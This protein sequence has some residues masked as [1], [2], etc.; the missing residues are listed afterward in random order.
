MV[1][2]LKTDKIESMERQS[3]E[4]LSR[5]KILN[6]AEI[7]FIIV[8]LAIRIY[9]LYFPF[10]FFGYLVVPGDDAVN[11]YAMVKEVM[12]GSY[13]F[14]YPK[15]FHLIIAK[16][17]ILSGASVMDLFKAITPLMVVLPSVAVYIFARKQ[18][19]RLAGLIGFA[20]MLWGGCNY[21]LLAFGDGN[22][23]NI[24]SAGFFMPLAFL[25]VLRA[26]ERGRYY[27]Y[28]LAFLFVVLTVLTHHLTTALLILIV[29][30]YL[31]CLGYWN[32][33]KKITARFRKLALFLIFL[34]ALVVIVISQTSLKTPFAQ[35]WQNLSSS[36]TIMGNKIFSTPLDYD[37]YNSQI[38]SFVWQA[39][40]L[41]LLI[42]IY[43][44]S[45]EDQA[46]NKVGYLLLLVWV[47]VLFILSRL[48]VFGLP[49]R[50]TRELAFPLVLSVAIVLSAILH[51]LPK[52][53]K[54]LAVGFVGFIVIMNLTQINSGAY[55]SPEYFNSMVWFTKADKE[56]TD[57]LQSYTGVSDKIIANPTTPYLPVFSEREILFPLGEYALDLARI[58]SYIKKNNAQYLFV[59]KITTANPDETAYPFFA[60]FDLITSRLKEYATD[61]E[62]EKDFGDGSVL[63]RL[64]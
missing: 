45:R 37:E 5:K 43:L 7:F 14:V 1:C 33:S 11:H 52:M 64:N 47:G 44:M 42:L 46:K 8:A 26:I 50:F 16:L 36:G 27:N 24:L 38:G 53:S 58:S 22:Y 55:K 60:G 48:E 30:I 61:L 17:S 6:Y 25:F 62:V 4:A 19:G 2:F 15:L 59:G 32:K 54:I 63:Y 10:N 56:K 13:N 57:Y 9:I 51:R 31:V 39:G 3:N 23:P 21:G 49:G 28:L 20:I 35:A 41:S 34:I 29:V 40:V 12:S 18:F